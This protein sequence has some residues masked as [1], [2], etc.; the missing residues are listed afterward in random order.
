MLTTIVCLENPYEVPTSTLCWST[1]QIVELAPGL[2]SIN[3]KSQWS[4]VEDFLMLAN[5]ISTQSLIR[6]YHEVCNLLSQ[7]QALK[8]PFFSFQMHQL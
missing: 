2:L 5:F 7:G 6:P 8:R 3:Y 1:F 4:C